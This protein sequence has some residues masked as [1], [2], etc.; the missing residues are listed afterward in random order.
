MNLHFIACVGYLLAGTAILS[1]QSGRSELLI[2]PFE[3]EGALKDSTAEWA[4]FALTDVL[5]RGLADLKVRLLD[6]RPRASDYVKAAREGRK[7]LV[8]DGTYQI[9]GGRIEVRLQLVPVAQGS[10]PDREFKYK[11]SWPEAFW[12]LQEKMLLDVRKHL[13]AG[14]KTADVRAVVRVIRDTDAYRKLMR[15]RLLAQRRSAAASA[16]DSLF[17]Q[18]LSTDPRSTFG[19]MAWAG[20]AAGQGQYDRALDRYRR[21]L[22]VDSAQPGVF[23][24]IGDIYFN[25]KDDIKA[26]REAYRRELTLRPGDAVTLT[27]MGHTYYVQQEYGQAQSYAK[28][29]LAHSPA[30]GGAL[31]LLGL[32]S[33]AL[34]DSTAAIQ[35][36]MDAAAADACEIPSRKNLARHYESTGRFDAAGALYR[37]IL[38]C[39][40]NDA[41]A[42]LSLANLLYHKVGTHQSAL[43]SF[44]QAVLRKPELESART[45]PIQ[46]IQWLTQN[47]K[48]PDR[49]MQIADTLE[50]ELFDLEDRAEEFRYRTALGF[51]YTYYLGRPS[52]AINHLEIAWMIRPEPRLHFYLGEAFFALEKWSQALSHYFEYQEHTQGSYDYAKGLQAIAKVLIKQNRFEEAQLEIL[53]SL[54]LYPNAESYF[55]YGV[56]LSNQQQYEAA[57]AALE[58]AVGLYPSYTDAQVELGHTYFAMKKYDEALAHLRMAA[59]LD[60]GRA[61][62]RQA[63]ALVFLAQGNYSEAE[64]EVDRALAIAERQKEQTAAYYGTRGEILL[65]L[66]KYP[67]ARVQFHRQV[68][69]DS[70]AATACYRL[71]ATYAIDKDVKNTV[72]WL[73]RAFQKDFVQFGLLDDERLFDPVRDSKPFHMLVS[74][75]RQEYNE[76]LM[77]SLKI[78]P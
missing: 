8:L 63:L 21:S 53:K 20:W 50:Y 59:A 73:E 41:L 9:A 43:L 1:A 5:Q 15:A 76:R 33:M 2:V 45:N 35:Y 29:A 67:E 52:D 62:L 14:S 49:L 72:L 68:E 13:A 22:A 75:Y 55:W 64:A 65:K 10:V 6:H 34:G 60:T 46:V 3:Q 4:G 58:K 18:A 78:K 37:E 32:C 42:H 71:A 69:L 17:A 19:W 39:D 44:V 77:K 47:R 54:R 16:V 48:S 30:S 61:A 57:V 70:G 11:H 12:E 7:Q 23:R 66:K 27:E 56:A 26:A 28:Q 40:E 24:R 51:C 25:H 31:N 36:F 74:R 38:A